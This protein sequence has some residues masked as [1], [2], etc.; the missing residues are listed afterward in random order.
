M[1][2]LDDLWFTITFL[3]V[4]TWVQVTCSVIIYRIHGNIVHEVIE[5]SFKFAYSTNKILSTQV[6]IRYGSCWR[7]CTRI[8]CPHLNVNRWERQGVWLQ[9]ISPRLVWLGVY[10]CEPC[11]TVKYWI[12][13]PSVVYCKKV[14]SPERGDKALDISQ[15]SLVFWSQETPHVVYCTKINKTSLVFKYEWLR[16]VMIIWKFFQMKQW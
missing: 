10:I 9:K 6:L 4:F 3:S 13:K 7:I 12:E 1:V 5:A 14:G 11:T 8:K 2:W 16:V 15:I